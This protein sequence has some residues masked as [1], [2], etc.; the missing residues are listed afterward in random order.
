MRNTD[1]P[2]YVRIL[3]PNVFQ[4][5]V[6]QFQDVFFDNAYRAEIRDWARRGNRQV[7]FSDEENL[8]IKASPVAAKQATEDGT[9][10]TLENKEELHYKAGDYICGP[11]AGGEYWPVRRDIFES[12][13][14]MVNSH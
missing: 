13:Y 6:S 3:I 8:Y 10:L 7:F 2:D 9:C 12:T 14:V 1:I 11:G 4:G 5:T